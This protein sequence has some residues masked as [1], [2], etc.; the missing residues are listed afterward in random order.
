MSALP[1]PKQ[2]RG[3]CV[4]TPD[5]CTTLNHARVGPEPDVGDGTETAN[6]RPR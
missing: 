6:L 4:S 3:C 5:P 2:G 1:D